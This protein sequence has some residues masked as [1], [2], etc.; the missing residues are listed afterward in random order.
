VGGRPTKDGPDQSFHG[1]ADSG[2]AALG[3][4]NVDYDVGRGNCPPSA[5][6]S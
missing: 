2:I 1:A 6:L 4:A 5:R 3:Y